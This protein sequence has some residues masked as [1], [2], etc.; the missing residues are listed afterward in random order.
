MFRA[1]VRYHDQAHALLASQK[2]DKLVVQGCALQV[3]LRRR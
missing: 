3:R 2:A 1:R